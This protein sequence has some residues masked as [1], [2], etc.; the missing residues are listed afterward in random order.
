[1]APPRKKPAPRPAPKDPPAQQD[2][3]AEHVSKHGKRI[4]ELEASVLKLK[5]AVAAALGIEV[6]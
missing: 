5:Q 3:L 2:P 6:E 4:S 1:M